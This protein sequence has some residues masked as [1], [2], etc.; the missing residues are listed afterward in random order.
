MRLAPCTCVWRKGKWV[1]RLTAWHEVL[2]RQDQDDMLPI[3]YLNIRVLT[4]ICRLRGL[5]HESPPDQ[6]QP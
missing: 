6:K 2:K 3:I 4:P 1:C 5:S